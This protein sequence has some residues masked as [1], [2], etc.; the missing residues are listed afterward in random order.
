MIVSFHQS[1]FYGQ[2]IFTDDSILTPAVVE[3]SFHYPRR[4]GLSKK[5]FQADPYC[6]LMRDK[7]NNRNEVL[8]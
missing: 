5:S 7:V 6:P 1:G 8:S 3:A 2:L 4:K